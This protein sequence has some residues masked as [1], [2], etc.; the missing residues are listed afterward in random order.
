MNSFV[1]SSLDFVFKTILLTGKWIGKQV[2]RC[3]KLSAQFHQWLLTFNEFLDGTDPFGETI[4]C[5]DKGSVL[6]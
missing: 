4:R 6:K 1:F 5:L 2:L 3:S